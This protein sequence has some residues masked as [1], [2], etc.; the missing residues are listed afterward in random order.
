MIKFENKY[1]TE[2]AK[3]Y[4]SQFGCELL[5][6]YKGMNELHKFKCACGNEFVTTFAKFQN[7]N[8]HQCNSCGYK[9][10]NKKSQLTIEE[11]RRRIEKYGC[12]LVSDTYDSGN[13]KVSIQCVCGNIFEQTLIN[14]EYGTHRCQ[15]CAQRISNEAKNKYTYE[16]VQQLCKDNNCELL[17]QK[18]GK[19]IG[20]KDKV[21][22]KCS[23]GEIFTTK[24]F[25]CL[26]YNKFTC[27]S[28]SYLNAP[29]SSGEKRIEEYLKKHLYKYQKEYSFSDCKKKYLLR[30][31]FAVFL[32]DNNIKLIEFDGQQHFKPY[33]YYGGVEKFQDLCL[34]DSIKNEY[35]K[36]NNIPLL[37]I[38][39]KDIDKV[40]NILDDYLIA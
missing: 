11:V 18:N 21:V 1:S 31:D 26:S 9:L 7:R 40:D 20:Y 24:L 23:C 30:F 2:S 15:K 13:Q 16:Y 10:R 35:C 36:N 5:G 32:N 37:R 19:F 8:K 22:I 3:Q 39:Y 27:T 14:Y 25:M 6:E 17:S 4:V 28:C 29:I 12:K 33:E 34:R 38:C